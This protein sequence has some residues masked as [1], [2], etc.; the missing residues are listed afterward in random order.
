MREVV[1]LGTGT[2]LPDPARCGSGIAVVGTEDW[3]LVDCGRGVTFRSAQAGLDV[4]RLRAVLLTHHHSDHV[5]D[6]ASLAITRWVAGV[7]EPLVV[8]AP[9]GPCSRFVET[10]LDGY[11]DQSF[12]GQSGGT[13]PRPSI[14]G[15]FFAATDA[16]REILHAGDWAVLSALVDHS[17]IEAAVGYRI[18]DPRHS[19]AVSGDTAVCDGIRQLSGGADILIH[20][21]IDS[22]RVAPELLTWN[23][24]ARS[25]GELARTTGASRLVLTHLI[26]P[27]GDPAAERAFVDQARSGGYS[28]QV[29][30]AADLLRIPL[31]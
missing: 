26:P 3:V 18:T 19:V 31:S 9:H 5:S 2:P 4:R 22:T 12:Y 8:V 29:I 28:G 11:E 13:A 27:P 25:V 10:S 24:S 30:V 6:L 20:Q 15:E 7:D 21:A 16:P 1:F 17:P 23:A 14:R